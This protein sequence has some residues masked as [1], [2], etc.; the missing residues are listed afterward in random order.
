MIHLPP[1]VTINRNARI[2]VWAVTPEMIDWWQQVGGNTSVESWYDA[3][4]REQK[5]TVLQFGQAKP[6]YKMQSGTGEVILN[7]NQ[8]DSN[9]ALMFIMKFSNDINTHNLREYTD[10]V[11]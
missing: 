7:F 8:E 5:T 4:G 11:Y 1:G 9:T 2:V 6:S 10:Y 3:K